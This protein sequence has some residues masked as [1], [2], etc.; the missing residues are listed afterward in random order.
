MRADRQ[1]GRE[2]VMN[3]RPKTIMRGIICIIVPPLAV[4]A[5]VDTGVVGMILAIEGAVVVVA[6][7]VEAVA[8]VAL[9]ITVPITAIASLIVSLTRTPRA[10]IK[11]AN[12]VSMVSYMP[13]PSFRFVK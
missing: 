3:Y 6:V 11:E 12:V 7:D 5:E 1:L 10:L 4:A 9:L 2:G 8:Q 13:L